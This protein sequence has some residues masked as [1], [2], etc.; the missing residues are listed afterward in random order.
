MVTRGSHVLLLRRANTG[1]RDG[2]LSVPAGH[3]D[4]DEELRAAAAREL[5]EE[6]GLEARPEELEPVLVMH[7]REDHTH[8]SS[9]S[10]ESLDFFLT[11]S[12]CQDEPVNR[13]PHKCSELLWCSP[14]EL[15]EDVIPYIR[16]ALQNVRER[17]AFDS[18]G[19]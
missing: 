3:L 13:E 4:G 12:D 5:R 15:P 18:F 1:Y 7:R 9:R 14:E 16:R 17:R 19:W 8:T 2:W 6:T 11:L 10:R